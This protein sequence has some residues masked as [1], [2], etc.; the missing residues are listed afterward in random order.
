M[1]STCEQVSSLKLSG[2]VVRRLAKVGS[3]GRQKKV[4][5]TSKYQVGRQAGTNKLAVTRNNVHKTA[6]SRAAIGGSN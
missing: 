4:G 1:A 3:D 2:I 5:N 6:T